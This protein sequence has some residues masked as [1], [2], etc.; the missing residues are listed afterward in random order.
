MTPTITV[1]ARLHSLEQPFSVDGKKLLIHMVKSGENYDVLARD[2]DTSTKVL[3]SLNFDAPSPLWVKSIIVI[4]P[5]L[6]EVDPT[7]PSFQTYLVIEQETDIESIAAKFSVDVESLRLYNNCPAKCT[8]F[9][10]DLVL[11][12]H[13]QVTQ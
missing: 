3:L 13:S 4:S 2:Y 5:G 11:I 6:L 8:L 1:T 10:N 12:P 9:V 7:L